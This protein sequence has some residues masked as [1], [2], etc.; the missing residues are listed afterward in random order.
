MRIEPR[1]GLVIPAI[2]LITRALACTR[3]AEQTHDRA[4]P[5]QNSD[6]EVKGAEPLLDVNVD[7]RLATARSDE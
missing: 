1:E 6:G 2:A 4:H 7:H 5:P 3:A